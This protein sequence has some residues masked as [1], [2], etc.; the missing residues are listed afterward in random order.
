MRNIETLINRECGLRGITNRDLAQSRRRGAGFTLIE[1]LVVIAIIAIL[2]ALL[3]PALR[4]ARQQAIRVSCLNNLRQLGMVD[5]MYSQDNRGHAIPGAVNGKSWFAP[6]KKDPNAITPNSSPLAFGFLLTRYGQYNIFYCPEYPG[7][8]RANRAAS[9]YGDPMKDESKRLI[10]EIPP[11]NNNGWDENNIGYYVLRPGV[12][13]VNNRWVTSTRGVMY[14]IPPNYQNLLRP[15]SATNRF[16][17]N[18]SSW[19]GKHYVF[20]DFYAASIGGGLGDNVAAWYHLNNKGIVP[21]GN[22][23]RADNSGRWESNLY[24]VLPAG[25]NRLPIAPPYN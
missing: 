5:I 15:P 24:E 21:G 13:L 11:S 7:R 4:S 18:R 3:M 16:S 12:E 25:S 19:S 8:N 23:L 2:A 20:S 10:G 1:M 14:P 22:N 6:R 17:Y 9:P